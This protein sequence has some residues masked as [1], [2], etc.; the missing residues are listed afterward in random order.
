MSKFKIGDRVVFTRYV[1][2]GGHRPPGDAGV[3]AGDAFFDNTYFRIPV[4]WDDVSHFGEFP[5]NAVMDCL[6]L[7]SVYNSPLYKALT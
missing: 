5:L 1:D 3:V 4:K 6:E 2:G 7:E